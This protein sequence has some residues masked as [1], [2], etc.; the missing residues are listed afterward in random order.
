MPGGEVVGLVVRAQA[1]DAR[2]FDGLVRRYQDAAVAYARAILP[3][4]AAAEDA[5][6]E[7]FVQAWRDLRSLDEPAAF[8]GWLRRIVFK[9]CDRVRRAARPTAPLLDGLPAT[10]EFD[11]LAEAARRHSAAS[12]RHAVHSLPDQ[13]REATLLY[14]FTGYSVAEAAEFLDASP[15][16][17]KNRLHAARA[18]LRKELWEMAETTLS[19]E[20]P[21]RTEEFAGDVLAR[22]L[23]EFRRQE[24]A[25]RF[26]ANRGLLDDGRSALEEVLGRP[27][28]LS[29]ATVRD[30][31]V[32]LRRKR[33]PDGIACLLMRYLA[34]A[35]GDSEKAWAYLHL[36][37]ALGWSGSAAGAVLAH[38]AFEAWVRDADPCL[39][40]AYPHYPAEDPSAPGV[41][42][43]DEVRLVFLGQSTEFTTA[44]QKVWRGAEYLA[45]VD[46]AISAVRPADHNREVRFYALRMAAN[47]C[48]IVHDFAPAAVY[49]ERMHELAAEC[50][51]EAAGAEYHSK[52]LIHSMHLDDT[53]KDRAAFRGHA[54]E[55]T[56]LLAR[57][58]AEAPDRAAWVREE[59]HNL[60]CH[61]MWAGEH[62]QALALLE[63]NHASGGHAVGYGWLMHAAALWHET[64]D[65]AATLDLLR[66]ARAHDDRNLAEPFLSQAEFAEMRDDPEFLAAVSR[67]G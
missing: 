48:V 22:V 16:A 17:I 61:L 35:L 39:S 12:V 9:Y 24:Q 59:R 50:A 6:Q 5:A 18:R 60:A 43:R 38:E 56:A 25:D 20:K 58:A 65:R 10:A 23:G 36:T 46:A 32:V 53:S 1:G 49:I 26:T 66:A 62:A 67:E 15:S 63:A 41:L 27:G 21:S 28:E 51:D 11:P 57:V 7:A 14:Y 2:A 55:A 4:R 52:A 42:S 54:A 44:Y 33:D 13:Q 64:R 34:Q 30:G 31:F 29:A 3:D 8:G 40:P 37:H 19:E 45:K 47:A